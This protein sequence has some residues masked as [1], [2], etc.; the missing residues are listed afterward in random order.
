MFHH[1]LF[2]LIQVLMV[3]AFAPLLIG[4][5]VMEKQRVS[6]RRFPNQFMRN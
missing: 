3:V 1:I 4:L 2:N 5:P 6:S